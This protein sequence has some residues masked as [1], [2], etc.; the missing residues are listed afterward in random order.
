MSLLPR[1]LPAH[2]LF[3]GS[4]LSVCAREAHPHHPAT[5]PHRHHPSAPQRLASST[6]PPPA[7]PCS[8]RVAHEHAQPPLCSVN[9]LHVPYAALSLPSPPFALRSP[10]P[11]AAQRAH[12]VQRVQRALHAVG[13]PRVERLSH[14]PHQ[15]RP[16]G[17]PRHARYAHDAGPRGVPQWPAGVAQHR[18]QRGLRAGKWLGR[19]GE[20]WRAC[21]KGDGGRGSRHREQK[22]QTARGASSGQC[23]RADN[24]A[25]APWPP[26][27]SLCCTLMKARYS[28]DSWAY[29]PLR[30]FFSSSPADW[31]TCSGENQRGARPL[32]A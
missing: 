5:A 28:S 31:R 11:S 6:R 14:G 23:G 4:T 24:Q 26:T 32:V 1:V 9:K 19:A 27:I 3:K 20:G 10:C 16:G 22:E 21:W 8:T 18:K 12:L 29:W 30:L 7:T 2:L 17:Q 13:V 15:R 25:V